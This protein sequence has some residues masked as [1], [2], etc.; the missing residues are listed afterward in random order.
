M[1]TV[2]DREG[3]FRWRPKQIKLD[4]LPYDEVNFDLI[5]TALSDYGFLSKYTVEGKEYGYIPTFSKHQRVRPDEAKSLL[6]S[7][8]ETETVSNEPVTNKIDVKSTKKQA[9]L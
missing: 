6:P 4:I 7:H 9:D 3:R 5:L 2:A 1:F 8:V